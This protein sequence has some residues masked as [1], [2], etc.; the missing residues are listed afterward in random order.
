MEGGEIASQDG[1][2][3]ARVVGAELN[4]A[5]GDDGV[6]GEEEFVVGVDGVDQVSAKGLPVAHGEVLVDAQGER[7]FGG[8]RAAF[9]L[10]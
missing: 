8:K 2:D 9:G 3:A 5:A 4:D 7:S 10:A 6:L 1:A